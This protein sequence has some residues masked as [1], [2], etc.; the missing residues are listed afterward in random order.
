MRAA[1]EKCNGR[2]KKK[3]EGVLT[4]TPGKEY[5]RRTTDSKNVVYFLSYIPLYP[6]YSVVEFAAK[7]SASVNRCRIKSWRLSFG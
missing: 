4:A 3:L 2:G 1:G 7:N 5:N 6:Q